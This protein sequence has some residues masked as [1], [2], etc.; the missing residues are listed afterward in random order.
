MIAF[1]LVG[2]GKRGADKSKCLQASK[3]PATDSTILNSASQEDM[4]APDGITD[5]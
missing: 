1:I 2:S 3:E 4:V 5:L